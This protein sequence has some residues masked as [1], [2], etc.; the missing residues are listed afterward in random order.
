[1]SDLRKMFSIECN[2]VKVLE[3]I[4]EL[5][6]QRKI[7]QAMENV[8]KQEHET[9]M[10]SVKESEEQYKKASV[11]NNLHIKSSLYISLMFIYRK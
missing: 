11:S 3:T 7:N 9:Q 2:L 6:T 4:G 10:T 5:Q 8:H 1:M